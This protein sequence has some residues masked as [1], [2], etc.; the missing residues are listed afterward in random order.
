MDGPDDAGRQQQ[1]ALWP[2]PARSLTPAPPS[3]DSLVTS[4]SRRD[5]S[6]SPASRERASSIDSTPGRWRRAGEAGQRGPP[7]IPRRSHSK[8]GKRNNCTQRLGPRARRIV[9]VVIP[10]LSSPARETGRTR[11]HCCCG[12]APARR[13]DGP[14]AGACR[15]R[16]V[17]G[18]FG[19]TREWSSRPPSAVVRVATRRAAGASP[20]RGHLMDQ[21]RG[22]EPP[23]LFLQSLAPAVMEPV[24]GA[25]GPAHALGDLAGGEADDVAQEHDLA[26]L[27]GERP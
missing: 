17:T 8:L 12:R 11:G 23:Q 25:L 27:V 15:P 6:G 2:C 9:V 16:S 4:R 19:V 26:L 10:T 20:S 24:N 5:Y 13:F 18:D 7:T 3:D 1:R 21:R 14:G 22:V